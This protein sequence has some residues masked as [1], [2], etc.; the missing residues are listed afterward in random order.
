MAAKEQTTPVRLKADYWPQEDQRL[1]A[2][3]IVDVTISEAMK[4]IEHGK[5]ERADPMGT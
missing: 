5:A 2:G 1:E 4:L 3:N